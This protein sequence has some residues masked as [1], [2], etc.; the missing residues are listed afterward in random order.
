MVIKIIE[1]WFEKIF[2]WFKDTLN[3][4]NFF[5]FIQIFFL[6]AVLVSV[7]CTKCVIFPFF[8]Q[9]YLKIEI[10]KTQAIIFFLMVQSY[11]GIFTLRKAENYESLGVGEMS[12]FFGLT[13]WTPY[14]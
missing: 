4:T 6:S 11:V 8:V 10:F 13:I 3:Q 1:I 7:F 14:E 2:I 9:F 12:W 5:L